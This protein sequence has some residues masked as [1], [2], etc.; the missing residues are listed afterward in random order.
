MTSPARAVTVETKA[1]HHREAD[2]CMIVTLSVCVSQRSDIVSYRCRNFS[3]SLDTQWLLVW[4]SRGVDFSS[5]I[6]SGSGWT[7]HL[8]NTFGGTTSG[9]S[10]GVLLWSRHH[11]ESPVCVRMAGLLS[12]HFV[13]AGILP[14]IHCGPHWQRTLDREEEWENNQQ[15]GEWEKGLSCHDDFSPSCPFRIGLV[16]RWFLTEW[17]SPFSKC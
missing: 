3:V 1:V 10:L 5:P 9:V 13:L 7:L 15:R 12:A 17:S 11:S 14:P 6:V 4:V 16:F 8:V 2:N